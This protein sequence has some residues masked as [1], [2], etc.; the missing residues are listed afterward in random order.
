MLKQKEEQ[1][2]KINIYTENGNDE[3]NVIEKAL[4]S[5]TSEYYDNYNKWTGICAMLCNY[6]YETNNHVTTEKLFH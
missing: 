3:I 6:G 4:M 5:L 1:K 2:N